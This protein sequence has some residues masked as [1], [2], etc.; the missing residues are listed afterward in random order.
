MSQGST[1]QETSEVSKLID[2]SG[3]NPEEVITTFDPVL[4]RLISQVKRIRSDLVGKVL[5]SAMK[6]YWNK[7]IFRES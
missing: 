1:K 2:L 4:H 5:L 6:N 3:H 7:V